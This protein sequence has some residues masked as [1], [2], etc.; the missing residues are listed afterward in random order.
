[1]SFV[2]NG[3]G[4]CDYNF[5]H[6]AINDPS[7]SGGP[8]FSLLDGVSLTGSAPE[9][10]TWAMMFIGFAGLAYAGLR[11]RQQIRDCGRVNTAA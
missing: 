8:P 10:S 4:G 2:N 7:A 1:M 9:P 3:K 5:L 11:N 6:C